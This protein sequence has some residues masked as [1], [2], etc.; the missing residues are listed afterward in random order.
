MRKIALYVEEISPEQQSK[1]IDVTRTESI[2]SDIVLK[3]GNLVKGKA[4]FEKSCS[5]CHAE[6]PAPSL[7][8]N[9]YTHRE[10]ARKIRGLSK[11]GIAGVI[12]PGFSVD[13]LSNMEL[14]DIVA[15][16]ARM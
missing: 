16:V 13:R 4:I 2:P 10:I 1:P 9:G 14:L 3:R 11:T 12:M 7:Y 6:G 15:Y 5:I 8:R